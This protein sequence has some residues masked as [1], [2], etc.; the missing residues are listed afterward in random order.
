MHNILILFYSNNMQFT[1]IITETSNQ[2]DKS[3]VKYWVWK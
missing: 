1:D 3:K 2:Y